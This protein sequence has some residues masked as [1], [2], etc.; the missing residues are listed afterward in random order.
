[1]NKKRE[2][3]DL[4]DADIALLEKTCKLDVVDHP[5]PEHIGSIYGYLKGSLQESLETVENFVS[6]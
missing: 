2:F 3:K 1:M 5:F 4:V 6:M